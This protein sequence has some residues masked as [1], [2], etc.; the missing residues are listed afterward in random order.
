MR[1]IDVVI[2]G[3]ASL[4]FLIPQSVFLI[5]LPCPGEAPGRFYADAR[6]TAASEVSIWNVKL[7]CM[8]SLTVV[9]E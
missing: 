2:S 5:A 4:R 1:S 9:S 7:S 6:T 8:N 3:I